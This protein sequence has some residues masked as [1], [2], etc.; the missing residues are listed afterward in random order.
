M[1]R[2]CELSSFGFD[3][4]TAGG[5]CLSARLSSLDIAEFPYL[6]LLSAR[7]SS[8]LS[9]RTEFARVQAER[10]GAE[11]PGTLSSCGQ[12]VVTQFVAL[13]P[14]AWSRLMGE[15]RRRMKVKDSVAIRHRSDIPNDRRLNHV[16][17]LARAKSLQRC[18]LIFSRHLSASASG[19]APAINTLRDPNC[20]P[21]RRRNAVR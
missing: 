1:G 20:C 7:D 2:S 13:I 12:A 10:F 6:E 18:E 21:F 17:C 19:R 8:G 11:M 16:G 15:R 4:E 14:S 5:T 3:A 9:C